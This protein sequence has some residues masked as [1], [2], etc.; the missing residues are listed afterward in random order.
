MAL[1]R[2][3]TT[4]TVGNG[5]TTLFSED[6]WLDGY[7]V[8]ELAPILYKTVPRRTRATRTVSKALADHTW[9]L[10]IVPDLTATMLRQF[11][12]LWQRVD[13]FNIPL[14]EN[15]SFKWAWE[16]DG[17]F[18]ARSVYAARFSGLQVAPM[19]DFTWKSR[20]PLH[21]C[22]FT[23]LAIKNRCWTSDRLARRGLSHQSSCPLCSQHEETMTH[24]MIG[25][26]FARE[27]WAKLCLAMGQPDR[28][29]TTKETLLEW[30]IRQEESGHHKKFA[31]PILHPCPMGAVD[32]P[33]CR[34]L[35]WSDA[36]Y[37]Q[38]TT[39]H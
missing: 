3:T 12:G 38:G 25:C 6:R 29:P 35:R 7:R 32:T 1:F 20:A 21:K 17:K 30:C 11:L 26:V 36:I 9:A 5:E 4:T 22:F 33:Q 2:A 31:R 13:R 28:T 24:I 27:V 19:A 8:E 16:K 34:S 14:T 23:W 39:K 37:G 15:D 18:S 10:E